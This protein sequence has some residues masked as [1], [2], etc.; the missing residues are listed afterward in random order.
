MSIQAIKYIVGPLVGAGAGA[1][2]AFLIRNGQ[3]WKSPQGG[4]IACLFANRVAESPFYINMGF[5]MAATATVPENYALVG[6]VV[7][8]LCSWRFLLIFCASVG[9]LIG[10]L[11]SPT[12]QAKEKSS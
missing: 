2:S 11:A 9:F 12:E 1:L 3:V 8:D 10:F 4:I 6:K 5:T 7:P